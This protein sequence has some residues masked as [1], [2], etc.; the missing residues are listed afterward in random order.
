MIIGMCQV[1]T[2]KNPSIQIVVKGNVTINIGQIVIETHFGLVCS[3]CFMCDYSRPVQESEPRGFEI[4]MLGSF[5]MLF[6]NKHDGQGTDC[7]W[8]PEWPK[9]FCSFPR[10]CLIC[11]RKKPP[12]NLP[13][14]FIYQQIFRKIFPDIRIMLQ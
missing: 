2:Y 7:N 1:W 8:S 5:L 9:L 4:H 10:I 14:P 6:L 3:F 12:V 11:E 13:W